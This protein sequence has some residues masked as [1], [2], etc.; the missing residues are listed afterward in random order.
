[1]V[2]T[3]RRLCEGANEPAL[4]RSPLPSGIVA[5][6][7]AGQPLDDNEN[8]NNGDGDND[9]DGHGGDGGG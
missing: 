2:P 8:D 7:G 6:A 3:G 9:D 4:R 1:M 5:R